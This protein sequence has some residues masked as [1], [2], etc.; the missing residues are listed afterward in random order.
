MKPLFIVLEGID[1]SGKSTQAELLYN[2]YLSITQPVVVSPEPTNGP[3]GKFIRTIL[4]QQV[5]LYQNNQSFDRQMSYLFA[6][7]RHYHVYNQNEGI[8][9]L[10]RQKVTIISTRYYFS[11]LAYHCQNP[12]DWELVKS[13]NQEFP[14][15]DL[16]IYLDIPLEI[17]LTRL[18][19][20]ATPEVYENK[21]KLQQ[22]K[23]NYQ[24][25]WREYQGLKL[26]LDATQSQEKIHQ[27]IVEFIEKNLSSD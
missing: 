18:A 12:R 19:E 6:A 24:V 10:L 3:I 23:S 8:L 20:R 27:Q 16:L 22:V 7:D 13:L 2:Y 17:C 26:Q 5:N 15:P 1:S 25:I 11:S 4:S 21:H 9:T 14:N